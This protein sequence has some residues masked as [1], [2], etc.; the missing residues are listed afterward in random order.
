MY[1]HSAGTDT[2]VVMGMLSLSITT[3]STHPLFLIVL[4]ILKNSWNISDARYSNYYFRIL[5]HTSAFQY[6]VCVVPGVPS[7]FLIATVNVVSDIDVT[8][9]NS[10][11][12]DGVA[13]TYVG[14]DTKP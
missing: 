3:D 4:T 5:Y 10:P 7:L 2:G 9:T 1:S 8:D 14:V 6:I 12:I 11:A 13:F